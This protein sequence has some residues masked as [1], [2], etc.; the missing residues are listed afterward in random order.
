[1]QN[2][3]KEHWTAA[4]RV[5]SYLKGTAESGVCY[6][7]SSKFKIHAYCDSDFAEH[8]KDRKSVG[9]YVIYAQGGPVIWKSKKQPVVAQSS[10]EAEYIALAECVKDLLWLKMLLWELDV[11]VELPVVVY[12][13]NA[14]A[15]ALAE[16]PIDHDRSKHIDIR[17]H[18]I[19]HHVELGWLK[20]RKVESARNVADVLTK[21][22]TETVFRRL[23][24]SLLNW[25]SLGCY[26]VDDG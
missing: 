19:R 15:K 24:R 5:L 21:P 6:I 18:L 2:A 23:G 11:E 13:D 22:V 9:A 10:A 4:K 16:N 8:R 12:I 7:R 17:Y 14:A 25:T 26:S 3:A 20:I 1:M